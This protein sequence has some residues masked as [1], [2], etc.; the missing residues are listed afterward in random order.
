MTVMDLQMW[1]TG[2]RLIPCNPS[3]PAG[4]LLNHNHVAMYQSTSRILGDLHGK[5][6]GPLINAICGLD[7]NRNAAKRR[8]VADERLSAGNRR[9]ESLTPCGRPK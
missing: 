4:V 9:S 6:L 5:V 8:S 1:T 7:W 2:T 3:Y